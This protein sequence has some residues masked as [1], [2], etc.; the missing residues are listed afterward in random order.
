M[1]PYLRATNALDRHRQR[2]T[3]KETRET[4]ENTGWHE[5]TRPSWQVWLVEIRGLV[6]GRSQW[7]RERH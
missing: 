6:D 1:V 5:E 7:T 3:E 2:D 4:P